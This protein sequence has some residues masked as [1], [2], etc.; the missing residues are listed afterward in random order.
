MQ[1]QALIGM[2]KHNRLKDLGAQ[3]VILPCLFHVQFRLWSSTEQWNCEL[4]S[5]KSQQHRNPSLITGKQMIRCRFQVAL[6]GWSSFSKPWHWN[7]LNL[8][9]FSQSLPG[10]QQSCA[11]KPEQNQLQMQLIGPSSTNDSLLEGPENMTSSTPPRFLLAH[12]E[13]FANDAVNW[14]LLPSTFRANLS[15]VRLETY[16]VGL[17]PARDSLKRQAQWNQRLDFVWHKEIRFR[18][19]TSVVE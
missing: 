7:A 11:R 19:S 6:G 16:Q 1:Q 18:I 9:P 4:V 8:V 12:G 2:E 17:L 3:K 15:Q 10:D 13:C 5:Q 14:K